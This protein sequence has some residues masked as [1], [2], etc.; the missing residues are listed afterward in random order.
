MKRKQQKLML[1]FTSFINLLL[2]SVAL[3]ISLWMLVTLG[4]LVTGFNGRIEWDILVFYAFSDNWTRLQV[5]GLY[6]FPYLAL[7]SI[8]IAL[9]FNGMKLKH[10]YLKFRLFYSW[11]LLLLIVWLFFLPF[12]EILYRHNIYFALDWLYFDRKEQY[13]FSLLTLIGYVYYLFRVSPPFSLCLDLPTY[14]FIKPDKIKP[15]L[16]Y[17][18]YIPFLISSLIIFIITGMTILFPAYYVLAGIIITMFI[19][20]IYIS[21]YRVIVE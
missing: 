11:L 13:L 14:Q 2:A 18:W 17:L 20:T 4:S 5:L 16:L 21:G 15:L 8:F 1:V 12:W 10:M 3:Q 19:N 7:F 9:S 6:L